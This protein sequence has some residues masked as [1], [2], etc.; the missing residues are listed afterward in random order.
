MILPCRWYRSGRWYP[1]V[2]EAHRCGCCHVPSQGRYSQGRARK[3]GDRNHQWQTGSFC[4]HAGVHPWTLWLKGVPLSGNCSC[5]R[6]YT[7]CARKT[8]IYYRCPIPIR[9]RGQNNAVRCRGGKDRKCCRKKD[10]S[11]KEKNGRRLLCYPLI[12]WGCRSWLVYAPW[13]EG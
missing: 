10:V 13:K 11:H 12:E 1:S 4:C 6:A 3:Y 8:S 2:P 7:G 9:H 5:S